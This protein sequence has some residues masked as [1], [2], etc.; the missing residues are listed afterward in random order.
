MNRNVLNTVLGGAGFTVALALVGVQPTAAQ[1]PPAQDPPRKAEE[2]YK[3]IQALKG[4][5]AAE[6][7]PTMWFFGGSLGVEC[8]YCHPNPD[9]RALETP[10]KIMA[11]RMLQMTMAIN[12][13]TFGGAQVVTCF[14]CHRG[15]AYPVMTPPLAAGQPNSA[16]PAAAAGTLT[17]QLPSVSQLVDKY[18]AA[19]GGATAVQKMSSF[20]AK[21]TFSDVIGHRASFDI[22]SK[23]PDRRLT[24]RH[25]ENGDVPVSYN[26]NMG[27]LVDTAGHRRYM[28]VDEVDAGKIENSLYY[29]GRIMQLLSSLSV[30]GTE[31]INGRDTYVVS[32]RTAVLPLVRLYFDKESGMI[33]RVLYY[34]Q[35]LVGRYATQIDIVEFRNVSGVKLP[36]RW[37]ESGIEVRDRSVTYQIE[38]VQPNIPIEDTKFD[39][40]GELH[41]YD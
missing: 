13:N 35:S 2:F 17:G 28:R 36:S 24:V 21:G 20:T 5:P 34:K 31:Q 33:V 38:S 25:L 16:G 3:N 39:L 22:L 9:D 32:G 1:S 41:K 12:S 37:I 11:R 29:P 6:L 19:L 40:S 15:S 30:D 27:W 14:T 26:S 4:T 18:V 10:Q 8:T 23:A 7:I